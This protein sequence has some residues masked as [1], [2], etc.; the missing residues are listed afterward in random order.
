M[1][2]YW[3]WT[4][5]KI[6]SR[7]PTLSSSK[8]ISG[9]ERVKKLVVILVTFKPP[10]TETRGLGNLYLLFFSLLKRP[11]FDSPVISPTQL[12]R[13]SL[14]TYSSL[15]S[16]CVTYRTSCHAIGQQ[17]LPTQLCYREY[18]EF[19]DSAFYS[20]AFFTLRSSLLFQ[21]FTGTGSSS[22]VSAGLHANLWNIA[23]AWLFIWITAIDKRF[24]FGRFYLRARFG[25]S[26]NINLRGELVLRNVNFEI[27][28]CYGFWAISP[29]MSMLQSSCFIRSATEL[30]RLCNIVMSISCRLKIKWEDELRLIHY[31]LIRIITFFLQIFWFIV[32]VYYRFLIS[33][34]LIFLGA[35]IFLIWFI[36]VSWKSNFSYIN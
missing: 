11:V 18:F 20:R 24:I 10:L 28:A 14:A 22:S 16:T 5:Q 21:G 27:S 12:V 9:F 23:S 35:R 34:M 1:T 19:W 17:L 33:A 25:Q 6:S 36:F 8:I 2:A 29:Y 7:L 32:W 31:R 13:Q 26:R 4:S 15:P 3:P 30:C